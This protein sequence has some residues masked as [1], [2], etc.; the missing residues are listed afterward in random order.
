M[1]YT[2]VIFVECNFVYVISLCFIYVYSYMSSLVYRVP[3]TS[4]QPLQVQH[5]SLDCVAKLAL[6]ATIGPTDS[7]TIMIGI[8]V[9]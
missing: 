6:A 7:F 8:A 3:S 9:H 4:A 2:E 5:I 1:V